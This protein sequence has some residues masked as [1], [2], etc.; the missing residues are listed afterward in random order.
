MS[1]K[2]AEI[3]R[4]PVKGLGGEALAAVEVTKAEGLRDDRRFALAPEGSVCDPAAPEW[5][6][7]AEFLQLNRDAGLASIQASWDS[8]AGALTLTGSF[9]HGTPQRFAPDRAEDSAAL[10]A[11]V[12][13]EAG[14]AC[15]PG[16]RLVHLPAGNFSDTGRPLVSIL[17]LATIAA[18]SEAA[19]IFLD[20]R[21]FRGNLL[22]EGGAPWEEFDWIG[23]KLWIGSVMLKPVERIGRCAATSVDP[24][25]GLRQPDVPRLLRDRFGHHHCGVYAEIATSGRLSIGNAVVPAAR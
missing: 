11:F 18:L 2:I 12:A 16:G 17:S 4:Y 25:T 21:R 1:I 13:A 3:W 9:G 6:Q 24:A 10:A 7:K 20:P 8:G 14:Q 23:T 19:G 15:R 22:V 5:H